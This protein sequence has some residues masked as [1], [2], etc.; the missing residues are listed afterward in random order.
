MHS[1]REHFYGPHRQRWLYRLI[2][3]IDQ[4]DHLATRLCSPEGWNNA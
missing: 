4:H 1:A 2:E 3:P